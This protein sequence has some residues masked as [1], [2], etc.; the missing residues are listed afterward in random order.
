MR[1]QPEFNSRKAVTPTCCRHICRLDRKGN[2]SVVA[3]ACHV[4][5]GSV[6]GRIALT[7]VVIIAVEGLPPPK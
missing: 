3:D 1:G 5:T 7:V 2:G 6:L 4:Q